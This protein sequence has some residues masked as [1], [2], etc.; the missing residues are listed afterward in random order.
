M[1]TMMNVDTIVATEFG[2][3]KLVRFIGEGG[4]GEVWEAAAMLTGMRVAIKF[5]KE[6]DTT[7]RHRF[8]REAKLLRSLS[9]P[10]IVKFI[11]YGQTQDD[12]PFIVM[13][14][15]FGQTLSEYLKKFG[16]LPLRRAIEIAR[17]IASVVAAAHELGI[18]HRDIKPANIFLPTQQNNKDTDIAVKV[19][20]LGIAKNTAAT[21]HTNATQKGT[22]LGSPRYMSPEQHLGVGV[23]HRTDIWAIGVVLYEMIQGD[24]LFTGSS[25][26]LTH[27]VMH[28]RLDPI[29]WTNRVVPREVSLIVAGCLERNLARRIGNASE[30]ERRLAQILE[31]TALWQTPATTAEIPPPADEFGSHRRSTLRQPPRPDEPFSL[32]DSEPTFP[33]LSTT[34][35]DPLAHSIAENTRVLRQVRRLMTCQVALTV[36]LAAGA[37][38]RTQVNNSLCQWLPSDNECVRPTPPAPVLAKVGPTETV[39]PRNPCNGS[40]RCEIRRYFLRVLR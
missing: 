8:C 6:D 19:L 14:L 29:P 25:L 18:V 10:N 9:H 33:P 27:E 13:E 30:I 3:Y 20:D 40:W 16:A 35:Q 24:P 2:P 17:H 39:D 34:K 11:D 1:A 38:G 32:D 5:L 22:I 7:L 28:R 31:S 15:L 36:V 21:E 4:M 23:D 37:L 12:T 26:S